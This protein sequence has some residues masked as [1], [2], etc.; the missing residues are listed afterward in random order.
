VTSL[1]VPS[2]HQSHRL[3][4]SLL[5][6]LLLLPPLRGGGVLVVPHKKK[7]FPVKEQRP[8]DPYRQLHVPDRHLVALPQ[9]GPVVH[10]VEQ[11]PL[12]AR[13]VIRCVLEPRRP[14]SR[15]PRR[16]PRSQARR[17]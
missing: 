10:P 5:P 12:N 7:Q 16:R 8:S 2:S 3:W 14:P 1:V 13:P 4:V 9:N 17:G 15:G 6:I 11:D